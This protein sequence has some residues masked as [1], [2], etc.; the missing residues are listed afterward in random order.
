MAP[1]CGEIAVVVKVLD[2]GIKALITA[3]HIWD[4]A[5]APW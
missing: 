4:K 2:S 5:V 1:Q 3:A